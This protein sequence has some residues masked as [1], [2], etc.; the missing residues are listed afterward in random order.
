MPLVHHVHHTNH[1]SANARRKKTPEE[2]AR[3]KARE[4]A[5]K[6]LKDEKFPTEQD[7]NHPT[8]WDPKDENP[9]NVAHVC[10]ER[11]MV[12]F[13]YDILKRAFE[14]NTAFNLSQKKVL[15]SDWHDISWC[16]ASCL[17][18]D[19]QEVKDSGVITRY[20]WNDAK[21]KALKWHYENT[22]NKKGCSPLS[23]NGQGFG[24]DKYMGFMFYGIRRDGALMKATKIDHRDREDGN[25]DENF[26][27]QNG[28]LPKNG[29]VWY[30]DDLK[31][32]KVISATLVAS[33]DGDDKNTLFTFSSKDRLIPEIE[34]ACK[35]SNV[36][37]GLTFHE[38]LPEHIPAPAVWGD[39]EKK[40]LTMI[41]DRVGILQ[42]YPDGDKLGYFNY[43]I[44]KSDGALV[45][46]DVKGEKFKYDADGKLIIEELENLA[47]E[48]GYKLYNAAPPTTTGYRLR[49]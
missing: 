11:L 27:Y 9:L 33:Y 10:N 49:F 32:V 41:N 38:H 34:K 43:G 3:D 2:K 16:L 8:D 4:E 7:G 37:W 48:V 42:K 24:V 45:R 36:S 44:R 39:K 5:R 47:F 30:T 17:L 46:A 12:K 25:Y 29:Q 31:N 1:A 35:K 40:A 18:D 20:G 19:L 15:N 21:R 22:N 13:K 6:V 28:F 14:S 23:E 26:S